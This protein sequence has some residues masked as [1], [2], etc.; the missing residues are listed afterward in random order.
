[1]EKKEFDLK[2]CP[3]CGR[4]DFLKIKAHRKAEKGLY[5]FCDYCESR[6]PRMATEE[7]AA[8]EWNSRPDEIDCEVDDSEALWDCPEDVPPVC[9]L[10][11]ELG[12]GARLVLRVSDDGVETVCGKI[13]WDDL[14]DYRWAEYPTG[15]IERMSRCV[16][17]SKEDEI[18]L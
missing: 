3:F 6:G 18:G 4:D 8:E 5:V 2:E 15:S 11:Q 7:E 10:R 9:W 12:G 16:K 13:D 14:G 1:M 17:R